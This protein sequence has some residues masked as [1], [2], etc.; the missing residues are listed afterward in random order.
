MKNS[1]GKEGLRR[2]RN[3]LF[4]AAFIA[5]SA[6]LALASCSDFY[7]S[8]WGEGLARDPS[9]VTITGSNIRELLKDA[10]GD[11]KASRAI[12]KKLTGTEDPEL[13]AA[14]VKAANQAAGLT[15]LALSNLGTLTGDNADNTD[16]LQNLAKTVLE[17]AKENDIRGI[18]DDI[19]ETLPLQPGNPPRFAGSFA[20]SISTS[21]LSLLLVTM[22]LAEVPNEDE[23]DDYVNE[24]GNGKKIDGNGTMNLDPNERVIAAIANEVMSRPDSELGK[25]LK[26]LVGAE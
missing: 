17:E 6:G 2:F 8:S 11:R 26:S 20:K 4:G 16:S 19:T 14:S 7:S 13:Q 1:I 10:N 5:L 15:E 21:D 24:W 3:P 25:M 9:N 12:L 22:M 23:F 18:A